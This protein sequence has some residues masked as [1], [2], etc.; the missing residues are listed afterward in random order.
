MKKSFPLA[1][2][3]AEDVSIHPQTLNHFEEEGIH[4]AP[5]GPPDRWLFVSLPVGL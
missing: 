3:F 5:Q 2:V 1:I 4:L